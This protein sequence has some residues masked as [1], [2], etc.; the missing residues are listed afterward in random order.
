MKKTHFVE[1]IQLKICPIMLRNIIGQ[2][3][4]QPWTDFQL[5]L[6]HIFGP[7]FP[8]S[9][10]AQTPIFIGSSA[11]MPFLWPTPKKLGTLFVNTTALTNFFVCPFFLHFCFWGFCCV[12]FFGFFFS[13]N[14]NKNITMNTKQ[15]KQKQHHKMQTKK[16]LSLVYKKQS[17]QHRHK[18][19][20][21]HCLDCKQTA[22]ETKKQEQNIKHKN[23]NYLLTNL[24]SKNTRIAGKT[25][26][27]HRLKQNKKQNK[28][29]KLK[30]RKLPK[31]KPT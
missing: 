9:K 18:T 10:Y 1:L 19:I 20:Q 31:T 12:Q 23:T 30:T 3:S 14:K 28:N 11:K 21:L 27:L 7:F 26:L 6:F 29:K 2:I 16:P 24:T 13:R 8:F 25:M 4:T 17:R 5:N 22:H 15:P